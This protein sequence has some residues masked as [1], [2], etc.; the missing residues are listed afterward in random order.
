VLVFTRVTRT[1][2]S[3]LGSVALAARPNRFE[4]DYLIDA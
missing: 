4:A 1:T 2:T 3:P